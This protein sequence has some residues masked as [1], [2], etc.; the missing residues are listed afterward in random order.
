MKV[1]NI[2]NLVL[3]DVWGLAQTKGP[4]WEKYFYS[5]TDAKS[6]YLAIYFGNAKDVALK[7]FAM[8]KKFIETQSSNKVKTF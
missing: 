2:S 5:F 8:F 1:Q 7:N 6:Q 4:A 3:S